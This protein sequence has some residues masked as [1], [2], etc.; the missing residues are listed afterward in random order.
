MNRRTVSGLLV[1]GCS[2]LVVGVVG[3]P[4]LISGI[5]PAMRS[6]QQSWRP[7]G[8]LSSFPTGKVSRGIISADQDAWPRTFGEQTVFV[9]RRSEADL[10]VFSRSCTDLGCPL[11][12][13]PGSGCFLCPCHGG[14]FAPDGRRLAGPASSPMHRYAHRIREEVLEIDVASIPPAS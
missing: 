13:E 14:I 7:V 10:V 9:W 5:S 2:A 8:D 3:I 11:E 4:V 1:V 6:R 12:Y